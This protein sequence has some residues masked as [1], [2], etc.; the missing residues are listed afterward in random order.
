[1]NNIVMNW[2]NQMISIVG[3]VEKRVGDKIHTF[4]KVKSYGGVTKTI[5]IGSRVLAPTFNN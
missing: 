4:A 1:M 2:K 5:F 3:K